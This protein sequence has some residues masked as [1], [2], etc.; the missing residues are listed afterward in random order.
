MGGGNCTLSYTKLRRAVAL[1][2]IGGCLLTA[3][4]GH[5]AAFTE[6]IT[7]DSDWYQQNGYTQQTGDVLRYEF[8][9]ASSLTTTDS[10]G[11]HIGGAILGA[12]QE[13]ELRQRLDITVDTL[14]SRDNAA[15]IAS[16]VPIRFTSM[17]GSIHVKMEG[18][19]NIAVRGVHTGA[20]SEV[21]L[22]NGEIFAAALYQH[23]NNV[24]GPICIA[25][26]I[27][28]STNVGDSDVSRLRFSG[29]DI[30]AVAQS[31][32][33]SVSADASGIYNFNSYLEIGTGAINAR[34]EGE[35]GA[36]AA[37]SG[38][39]A[40]AGCDLH[41]TEGGFI[42]A[43]AKSDTGEAYAYGVLYTEYRASGKVVLADD[44]DIAAQAEGIGFTR[45]DG[46]LGD[47]VGSVKL[48]DGFVAA[49][50]RQGS[51]GV[52]AL[53]NGLY[54]WNGAAIEAGDGE[55]NVAASGEGRLRAYGL[56]TAADNGS[57]SSL[58]VGE[59]DILVVT[60]GGGTNGAEVDAIGI[61]A[62][63]GSIEMA[64]GS[65]AA[66]AEHAAAG[67]KLGVY[68]IDAE[69]SGTQVRLNAAGGHRVQIDGEIRAYGGGK[70]DLTLDTADSYLKGLATEAG[71]TVGSVALT[72]K[73]GA[74]WN[75]SHSAYNGGKASS[76]TTLTAENGVIRQNSANDIAIGSFSGS[77][78]LAYRMKD[79]GAFALQEDQGAIKIGSVAAVGDAITLRADHTGA[80]TT[81]A[82][83]QVEGTLG[84][85]A[86]KLQAPDALAAVAQLY[87]GDDVIAAGT[88]VTDTAGSKV[89]EGSCRITVKGYDFLLDGGGSTLESLTLETANEIKNQSAGVIEIG[90]LKIATGVEAS[91][92]QG[93]AA[94]DIAIGTFSG[95]MT[96]AYAGRVEDNRLIGIEDSGALR[97]RAA[98]AGSRIQMNIDAGTIDTLDTENART[99]LEAVANQ[100]YY[101]GRNDGKL[102]AE[103]AINEGRL[104]PWAAAD[105][106]FSEST[107]QGT[108][109]GSAIDAYPALKLGPRATTT[110]RGVKSAAAAQ[111]MAWRE[112]NNS[113]A[114]R[115]G[116]LRFAPEEAGL[117]ARVF[118]GKSEYEQGGAYYANRYRTVQVGYDKRV[119][120]DGWRVGGA[121]SYTDGDSD[122]AAGT[123][124]NSSTA[125]AFYGTWTGE[126]GHYLD[127]IAKASR[128]HNEYTI[129][130][131]D[132]SL[133]SDG[134]YNSWGG[135]LSAEYGRRIAR[136]NGWYIE[137]QAELAWGHMRGESY[138]TAQGMQIRQQGMDSLVGRLG[139][140]VGRASE[141]GS[142]Y[143]K[144]S[145]AHEFQG[146]TG[147]RFSEGGI[148]NWTS[149]DFGDTWGEIGIGGTV[150]IGAHSYAY[151]D[152]ERTVGADVKVP[153]R[154]NAGVRWSF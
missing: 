46:V 26:G 138:R 43:L 94:G 119:G 134:D 110:M 84:Q 29:G 68:A 135:S 23:Q 32:A 100:L 102:T 55:I 71:G 11:V 40:K 125:L 101:D 50:A 77:A 65:I 132:R 82:L 13:I 78:T 49:A 142:F 27:A 111:I 70:V 39:D 113:V 14:Y 42:R 131:A 15:G 4:T 44:T 117:W 118:A 76:V 140:A 33:Q 109:G 75:N 116:D 45:A 130:S 2:C 124:E 35:N 25:E 12:I 108:I 48:G 129:Y 57:A 28:V 149:D 18:A 139:L 95:S 103:A 153:Y 6:R 80:L 20:G 51:G 92:K 99:A 30:T 91:V 53:A 67:A 126:R 54:A 147:V 145:L 148:E 96:A 90:A 133:H 61:F 86:D 150:R 62:A 136:G 56:H 52:N 127:L 22:G 5:A 146:K 63:A 85:L 97:V 89:E 38:I 81:L 7:G 121:V 104:T 106:Q 72:L 41:K 10:M 151:A 87:R 120:A 1:A 93:A 83:T 60:Q 143:L 105:M 47:G 79:D 58:V 141:K 115:L 34:A 137:P 98:D 37:A 114:K 69:N 16:F 88:L 8:G 66:R 73:N 9:E 107:G 152:V 128:L 24:S 31:N 17:G 19:G 74:L 3:G 59:R 64:G 36:T 112:E 122:F 154:V 21:T 123:G 144:A